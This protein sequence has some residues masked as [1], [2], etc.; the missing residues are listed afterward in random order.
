MAGK[1][2][3]MEHY[4]AVEQQSCFFGNRHPRRRAMGESTKDQ[5]STIITCFWSS[6]IYC[7]L[8]LRINF[9]QPLSRL[10][11]RRPVQSATQPLLFIFS[12]LTIWDDMWLYSCRPLILLWATRITI[13][14]QLPFDSRGRHGLHRDVYLQSQLTKNT[15]QKLIACHW[16]GGCLSTWSIAYLSSTLSWSSI[17]N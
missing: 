8:H 1:Y 4:A 13:R 17:N 3:Y 11:V 15:A 12:L 16:W 10:Q 14:N 6:T 7:T 2:L 5:D 9:I